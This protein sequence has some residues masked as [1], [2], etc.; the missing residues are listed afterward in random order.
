MLDAADTLITKAKKVVLENNLESFLAAAWRRSSW[1]WRA[2][3]YEWCQI[4]AAQRML[5][6]LLQLFNHACT[7]GSRLTF[8]LL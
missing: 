7:P 1:S 3:K 4:I 5:A 8:K 6:P 2:K